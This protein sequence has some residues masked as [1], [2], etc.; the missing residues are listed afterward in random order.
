MIADPWFY[1]AALPAVLLVGMAKGGFGGPI[2][3]LGV[4][5][6][7]LVIPPVQAA[8]IMLPILV[9]MDI[10]GL[11]AYRGIYHWPTLRVM[12]PGALVGI[13]IGW[14]TAAFV[15]EAHVR[16]I[17]GVIAVAFTLNNW[18]GLRPRAGAEIAAR[19]PGRLAGGVWGAV[20]G[21]TSFVSHAG[22]PPFNMYTLPL[23]L[24][25]KLLAGTAVIFF[26]IVNQVKLIPYYL[27]GQFSGENLSTSA[28]L[29]PVAVLAVWLGV[30]L[31]R[32]VEPAQFYRIMYA[33]VFV[34]GL[35][36]TAD[37]MAALL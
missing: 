10:V 5:L 16:L 37:G 3:L 36:L 32:K 23:R 2:A 28:V 18:F 11:W 17:V 6:M 31:V 25:P 15:T 7:S 29:L 12:L 26:T 34:V 24:D 9:V 20:S 13:A 14:A 35:K 8:G 33:A 4:P 30:I 19:D 27:L 21:F 1:V 22:G